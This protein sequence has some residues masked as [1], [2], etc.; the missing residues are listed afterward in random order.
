MKEN[1]TSKEK[2]F[3]EYYLVGRSPREAAAKSGYLFPER[4][5]MKLMTQEKIKTYLE[6][7]LKLKNESAALCG[8]R[9]LAFGST[10]DAAQLVFCDETP[11]KNTLEKMD[12]FLVS[13]IKRP[14]G[15]GLEIKFFDRLKALEKLEQLLESSEDGDG[16]GN[17]YGAIEN[18]AL[19][20][21]ECGDERED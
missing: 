21:R 19:R 17:I 12:L 2:L 15:G 10:A 20:L 4:A 14:K 9:K 13:E 18:S 16:R 8:Y 11:D 1:L 6:T 7:R 5:G 3:C